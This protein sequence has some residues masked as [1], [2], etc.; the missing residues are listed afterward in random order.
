MDTSILSQAQLARHLGND[1]D[2]CSHNACFPQ[3]TFEAGFARAAPFVRF[4]T[5]A[6]EFWCE[7]IGGEVEEAVRGWRPCRAAVRPSY[8]SAQAYQGLGAGCWP[9]CTP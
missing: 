8:T 4:Q 5:L 2:I 9:I 6:L 3:V 1:A 7:T